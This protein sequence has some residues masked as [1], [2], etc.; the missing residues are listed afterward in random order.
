MKFKSLV[1]KE[2]TIPSIQ[3]THLVRPFYYCFQFFTAIL[4]VCSSIPSFVFF[5][6]PF[7]FIKTIQ[8]VPSFPSNL[9]MSILP[10]RIHCAFPNHSSP[11][12]INRNHF[13]FAA[14]GENY[15]KKNH[16]NAAAAF[17]FSTFSFKPFPIPVI[18]MP[19]HSRLCFLSISSRN[20]ASIG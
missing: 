7:I 19:P 16:V 3:F 12:L 9:V 6:F 20:R 15:G 13:S 8:S 18:I 10:P 17:L 2:S 1:G 5:L 4:S 14:L 11:L